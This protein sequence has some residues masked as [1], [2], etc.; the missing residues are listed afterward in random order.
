MLAKMIQLYAVYKYLY[1]K[2]QKMLE[3]KEL[4]MILLNWQPIK[5]VAI[6]SHST[7]LKRNHTAWDKEVIFHRNM[8]HRKFSYE[9]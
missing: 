6:I 4:K 3:V 9:L 7:D 5:S 2:R 8:K 1:S